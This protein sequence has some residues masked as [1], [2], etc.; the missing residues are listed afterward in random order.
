MK[1]VGKLSA[2]QTFLDNKISNENKFL[3]QKSISLNWR[4]ISA[5]F[6]S[7]E[8]ISREIG[9]SENILTLMESTNASLLKSP[10]RYFRQKRQRSL[11]LSLSL[12]FSQCYDEKSYN[13]KTLIVRVNRIDCFMRCLSRMRWC[14]EMVGQAGLAVALMREA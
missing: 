7:K 1:I 10:E 4:T 12:P 3:I 5:I 8:Q 13:K 6:V 2:K 9:F 11:S 14:A